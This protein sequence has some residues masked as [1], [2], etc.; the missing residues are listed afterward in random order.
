[1]NYVPLPGSVSLALRDLEPNYIP[2][3]QCSGYISHVSASCKRFHPV[4][5][6]IVLT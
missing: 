6:V 5:D 2:D 3:K 4:Y 1:M